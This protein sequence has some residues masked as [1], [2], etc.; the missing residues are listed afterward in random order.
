MPEVTIVGGGAAGFFC[1]IQIAESARNLGVAVPKIRILEA[2]KEPLVKVKISGGGRCN[3]THACF[4]PNVLV[5]NY[6]RGH[7]ELKSPFRQFQP[8]DM[9]GWLEKHRVKLKTET[10]GRIFPVSDSSQTI[11]DCFLNC[12]REYGIQLSTQSPCI[13]IQKTADR[14]DLQL[15][16]GEKITA[17]YVV[18]A[19]GS[20]PSGY[21]LARSLGHTIVPPVPSLFT[22]QINDRAIHQLMG[23]AV[24]RVQVTL[25]LAQPIKKQKS[26]TQ[27]G[28][29]LFTHWGFSGPVI[30][31]LS[32]W[33]AHILHQAKYHHPIEVNWLPEFNQAQIYEQL[34]QAKNTYPKKQLGNY[35]PF[36]LPQ[37]LWHYLLAKSID[38]EDLIWQ[39]VSHKLLSKL[40]EKITCSTY[41]IS[42]KG[43]FK[44]EFVTCG[45]IDMKEVNLQTMESKLC[46]RLYFTGEILNIDGVTGGFNFQSAWTTAYLAG[47]TIGKSTVKVVP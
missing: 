5:Q 37:R 31:K 6:P 12:I 1:G 19:T 3:V 13:A 34:V 46:P 4:E 47:W 8:Q 10:D 16:S 20:H 7:Q 17:N 32:A 43:V 11:I 2:G 42:G 28:N 39:E 41:E 35:C 29:I 15:K 30:L 18:L 23:L 27:I 21:Q 9:I 26:I 44:D 14:F 24:D 40:A 38:R 45:G 36:S 22:F 33:S 25:K